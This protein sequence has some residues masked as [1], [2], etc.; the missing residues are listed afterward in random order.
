VR[1]LQPAALCVSCFGRKDVRDHRAA[2]WVFRVKSLGVD[3]T[4]WEG[5]SVPVPDP[6]ISGESNTSE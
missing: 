4:L 5:L 2:P 6:G 3:S 1:V